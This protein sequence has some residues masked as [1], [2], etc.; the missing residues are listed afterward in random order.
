MNIAG[1]S[2][3]VGIL[4]TKVAPHIIWLAVPFESK[5]LILVEL[6][7]VAGERAS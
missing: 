7:K 6:C 5:S 1:V 2:S 4:T 3:A